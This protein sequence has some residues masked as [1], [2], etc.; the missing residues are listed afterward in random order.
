LAGG[1]MDAEWEGALVVGGEK[2]P[3]PVGSTLNARYGRF[4][5]H[6]PPGFRGDFE[7]QFTDRATGATQRVAVGVGGAGLERKER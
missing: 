7:L 2:R 6:V 5:W 3:L 1:A 4:Y